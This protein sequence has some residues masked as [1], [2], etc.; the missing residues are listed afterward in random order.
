MTI[1]IQIHLRRTITI[2]LTPTALRWWEW[3]KIAGLAG[4]IA[5]AISL[6]ADHAP[7]PAVVAVLLHVAADFTCQSPETAKRK[8]QRGRHLLIHAL[9]AGGFPLAVAG[10]MTG[11]PVAVLAWVGGG[12]ASHYGVDW[13][14]KF[15]LPQVA[16]GVIL[17]Q[18][19]HLAVILALTT[20]V[21]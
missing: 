19:C 7:S 16:L 11:D 3:V 2:R 21:V 15:G 9:S 14:R 5:L 6:V 20:W 10:L 17:D 12:I 4:L 18:V 8:G 1:Q 13:T